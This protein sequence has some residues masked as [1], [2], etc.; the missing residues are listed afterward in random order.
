MT[1]I[2]NSKV[3]DEFI[4]TKQDLTEIDKLIKL[5]SDT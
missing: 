3:K 2:S 4:L 1:I 5:P